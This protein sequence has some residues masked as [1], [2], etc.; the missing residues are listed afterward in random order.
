M[1]VDTMEIV[2]VV[3][4]VGS[5]VYWLEWTAGKMVATLDVM[6]V[7]LLAE[8]KGIWMADLLDMR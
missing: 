2:L 4:M 6:T 7:G 8:K 5:L 3:E 1:T